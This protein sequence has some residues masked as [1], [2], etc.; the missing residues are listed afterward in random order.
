MS[1]RGLGKGLDAIFGDSAFVENSLNHSLKNVQEIDLSKI[2]PNK[3]QPRRV[4]EAESLNELAGSIKEIGVIQ[5]VVVR[6]REDGYELVYGERRWRAA[7]IA[8][9]SAI[10]ALVE[11]YSDEQ[12]LEIALIENIQR[13]DLNAIEEALA[14]KELMVKLDLTQAELSQ[15]IGKSR[16]V[17][18]NVVRLLNLHPEVQQLIMEGAISPGQARPLLVIEDEAAQLRAARKII[19]ED[20]PARR[21]EELVKKMLDN[22]GSEYGVTLP[23]A[24]KKLNYATFGGKE[25]VDEYEDRLCRALGAK[26]KIKPGKLKSKI[27]IEVYSN[28][29]LERILETFAEDA[30]APRSVVFNK[31][32]AV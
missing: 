16:P 30:P 19:S 17:I 4:F 31:G 14:Y 7:A 26:V 8:G 1:K 11:K 25:Y 9:L 32:F 18:A 24:Q 10:P 5:P 6:Q 21:V 13:Q 3:F 27:E 2:T 22:P 15:K 29:D 20:H 28:E 12:M 23:P